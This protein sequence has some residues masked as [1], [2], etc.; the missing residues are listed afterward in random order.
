MMEN[1]HSFDIENKDHTVMV[2]MDLL[3]AEVGV[4]EHLKKKKKKKK[5]G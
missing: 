1:L 3:V 5:I 2:Y 4:L